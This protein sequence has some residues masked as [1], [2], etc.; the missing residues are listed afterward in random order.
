MNL[1]RKHIR[2]TFQIYS[3]AR[4]PKEDALRNLCA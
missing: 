2:N 3:E 4:F 1:I